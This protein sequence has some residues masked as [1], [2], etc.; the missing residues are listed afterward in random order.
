MKTEIT[1]DLTPETS[2]A[3]LEFTPGVRIK[4]PLPERAPIEGG[5]TV[6]TG[7]WTEREA[8]H[9]L[10]RTIFGPTREQIIQAA[11]NGMAATV[12]ALLQDKPE[13]APPINYVFDNDPNTP[14]G[15]TWIDKPSN[16]EFTA[17]RRRSLYAW[18]TGLILDEGI[19][20]LEKMTLFWHNHFVTSNIQSPKAVYQYIALLRSFALGNFKELTK[21]IT[22]NPAML[23]Y[24][25]GNENTNIAP[26]E[27]YARELLEL[28]TVGKGELAGPGDYT[29]FTEEDVLA[30]AKILTG[31]TARIRNDTG[32]LPTAVFR[33]NRHDT[34]TKTLSHRFG[35]VQ[36]PNAGEN[37][38]AN[39]VD[40]VFDHSAASRYI[41]RKLYRWFVYYKIDEAIETDVI[42]PMAQILRDNDFEIKPVLEALF[43][44]EHFYHINSIGGMIKHP[45]E[46][47]LGTIKQFSVAFPG[48]T[49]QVY[50]LQ[51]GLSRVTE[52]LQM[53]YFFPPDVAGWKPFYQ[54]PSYFQ[55]WI[56][57]ATWLSRRTFTDA[58]AGVGFELFDGRF[59][60]DILDYIT[61]L[62]NP[63]NVNALL[64][65][66][67]DA[68]LPFPLTD[69]Q[70]DYLKEI[71]IPGLPDFEW[72]V[73]YNLY[74]DNPDDAEIR[75]SVEVKLQSMLKALLALPEFQLS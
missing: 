57:S 34:S 22:I 4:F 23:V 42:E 55:L 24:L 16:Q 62:S 45:I 10:R 47:I 40:I 1:L 12:A 6:Y 51:L 25:N 7:V 43:S 71:L 18:Q 36:V 61:Q 17:Y 26:N 8:A 21:A 19:S 15:E 68:I 9:L 73:E 49:N 13:P 41:C 66:L 29:T 52:P 56:N 60:I 20:V 44:S 50:A 48:Q 11:E 27:N 58:I 37:E 38:Y 53:I 64:R 14:I 33:S 5:L 35:N 39:L 69:N 32:A 46:F 54:E 74:L 3:K 59:G 63:L 31:W 2:S 75:R 72:T 28:F 70:L 67:S 65:D 30:M